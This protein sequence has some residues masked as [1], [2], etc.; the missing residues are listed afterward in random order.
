MYLPF[1]YLTLIHTGTTYSMFLYKSRSDS[2]DHYDLIIPTG[3][4]SIP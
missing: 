2:S 4:L 3:I 1:A